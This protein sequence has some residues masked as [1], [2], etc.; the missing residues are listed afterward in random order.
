MV[1]FDNVSISRKI[2][3]K[4]QEFEK[5]IASHAVEPLKNPNK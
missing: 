4:I 3:L 5:K 2:N 1:I